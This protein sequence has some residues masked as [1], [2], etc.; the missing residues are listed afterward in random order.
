VSGKYKAAP[1]KVVSD[2][3]K[4]H[5]DRMHFLNRG[6]LLLAIAPVSAEFLSAY[7]SSLTNSL[8]T[9]QDLLT[10]IPLVCSPG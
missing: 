6:K 4:E 9:A 3:I 1:K 10:H 2:F 7:E 8:R 5:L